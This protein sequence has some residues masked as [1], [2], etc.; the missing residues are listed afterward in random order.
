M[1]RKHLLRIGNLGVSF[2]PQTKVIKRRFEGLEKPC[3][4]D[5]GDSD[6]LKAASCLRPQTSRLSVGA[7]HSVRPNTS[8][9]RCSA[10]ERTPKQ[11]LCKNQIKPQKNLGFTHFPLWPPFRKKHHRKPPGASLRKFPVMLATTL[12]QQGNL[13]RGRSRKFF[14]KRVLRG[15]SGEN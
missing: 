3:L 12:V 7:A 15:R 13:A 2:R 10:S 14:S 5:S 1:R 4:G 11:P 8:I 6:V 9:T